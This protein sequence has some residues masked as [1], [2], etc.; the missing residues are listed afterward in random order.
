MVFSTFEHNPSSFYGTTFNM[1]AIISSFT[2]R[3]QALCLS[4]ICTMATFRNGAVV[5]LQGRQMNGALSKVERKRMNKEKKRVAAPRP[6]SI[7]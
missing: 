6:M 5:S 1:S 2:G 4:D 7:D 3:L